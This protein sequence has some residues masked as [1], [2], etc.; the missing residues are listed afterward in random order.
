[1]PELEATLPPTDLSRRSVL[2]GA[3]VLA[4]ALLAGG[5][6]ARPAIGRS[7]KKVTLVYGVQTIDSPA[8]DFFA[9][10][11]MGLDLYGQEGLDVRVETVAGA[12]AAVNLLVNGQAQFATHGTAGLFDAIDKG[13]PIQSFICEIPDFIESIAV[14]ADGPI[15]SF[16]DLKGKTI[17]VSANAGA[18][19]FML[20]AIMR[21]R[22]WNPDTDVGLLA[23]GT[24]LP[25]L[26][27]L[28]RGRV[29]AIVEWDT[30]FAQFEFEG[31]KFRYFRPEPIPKLG[32]A[33][34]TNTTLSLMK[35]D[36]E[37][38]A[39]LGRAIAKAIVYMAAAPIEALSAVHYKIYPA[40]RPSG[41]THAQLMRLNTMRL[42]ARLAFMGI[43]ARVFQR[44]VKIGDVSDEKIV[45]TRDLLYTGGEI[46]KR[47]PP[48]TYFTRRY[49]SSINGFDIPALIAKAKA[50]KA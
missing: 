47:Y 22:G 13:A 39:G 33:H 45:A 15:K 4:P 3:G 41:L 23:V 36:P 30:I 50:L 2:K 43:Q 42:N 46:H 6:L 49:L 28:R 29:Q 20:K 34:A 40:S 5:A 18:P 7:M 9:A 1:M 8:D 37:M 48:E 27:A 25:A 38:V 31:A 24:G 35:S 10:I 19:V 14:L 26:D 44:T 17:G 11:P 21:E 12:G 16:D 32:F